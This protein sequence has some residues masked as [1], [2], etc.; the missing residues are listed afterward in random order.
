MNRKLDVSLPDDVVA[1]INDAVASGQF[2][3][4]DD[5]LAEAVQ[6]WARHQQH[7]AGVLADMRAR[8]EQS[9]SDSRPSIPI[10]EAFER[11]YQRIDRRLKTR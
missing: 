10:D 8:I 1:V 4:T 7:R 11:L 5:M 6:A 9:L 3:T 2:E